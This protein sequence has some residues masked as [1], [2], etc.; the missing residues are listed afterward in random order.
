MEIPGYKWD[1]EKRRY[2]KILKTGQLPDSNYTISALA[3]REREK[4][5]IIA[6]ERAELAN[7][8]SRDGIAGKGRTI[9]VLPQN[10]FEYRKLGKRLAK[11]YMGSSD[12]LISSICMT[13]Q[14]KLATGSR[15][16]TIAYGGRKT[17]HGRS[18]VALHESEGTFFAAAVDDGFGSIVASGEQSTQLPGH[19]INCLQ[20]RKDELLIG[21]SAGF[22]SWNLSTNN[23]SS[24]FQGPVTAL[25]MNTQSSCIIGTSKGELLMQDKLSETPYRIAFMENR[26]AI[27]SVGL[28]SDLNSVVSCGLED[29]MKLF[30]LRKPNHPVLE[31]A[32][33]KNWST[34]KHGFAL[35]EA[36]S[37]VCVALD[38]CE[39]MVWDAYLGTLLGPSLLDVDKA[40][41][42]VPPSVLWPSRGLYIAMMNSV[43]M[44]SRLNL[45]KASSEEEF[46]TDN[47]VESVRRIH[48]ALNA[49]I[50]DS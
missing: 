18:I 49:N 30:D 8:I 25:C 4:G 5:R 35:N 2:Y 47:E 9:N 39:L 12:E 21:T 40:T 7:N 3:D 45:G 46:A 20:R 34:I 1:P 6:S 36:K 41:P 27:T 44:Q 43:R 19:F 37:A 16:G 50:A 11:A 10:A 22:E 38:T 32:E 31:F 17:S 15:N 26:R 14:G 13:E 33:Y 28:L 42:V 24:L 29:E 23:R 48:S